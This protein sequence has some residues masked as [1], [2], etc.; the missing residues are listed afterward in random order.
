MSAAVPGRV[1]DILADDTDHRRRHEATDLQTYIGPSL[2]NMPPDDGAPHPTDGPEAER[3][4]ELVAAAN[5]YAVARV[6]LDALID[7]GP[8]PA[9]WLIEPVIAAGRAH[10]VVAPPKAGKSLLTLALVG[11]ACV[12]THPLN[13]RPM[14][15]LKV[16]YVDHEMTP[17][18]LYERLDDLG[19]TSAEHRELLAE[20]LLYVQLPAS[21][22]LDTMTGAAQLIAYALEV[23]PDLVVVDTLSRVT[24]GPEN[25]SDTYRNLYR[26]AW[27]PLKREGIAVLRLDHTGHE[28]TRARGSS[29][30]GDD[31][32]LVWLLKPTDRDAGWTLTRSASRV[33]WAPE[34]VA[35]EKELG[36]ALTL[37]RA[38]KGPLPGVLDVVADLDAI[39]W[40]TDSGPGTGYR[41]AMKALKAAGRPTAS[42]AVMG[43]ALEFR[44]QREH[45]A[46]TGSDLI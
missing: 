4:A 42:T 14:A 15:P 44:R 37:R 40:T 28:G 6:D 19:F 21:E 1:L 13:G 31:V 9:D 11:S 7:R 32:D 34:S 5:P 33:G 45:S 29:A 43:Q 24:E 23:R 10:A 16:L 17:D 3:S 25:D 27:Q 30:K 41:P 39:G 18:D 20:N 26:L 38:A 2:A 12:G 46:S 35:I 8:P 22:P 36:E